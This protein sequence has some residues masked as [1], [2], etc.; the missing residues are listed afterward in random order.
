M[1]TKSL[2]LI[3]ALGLFSLTFITCSDDDGGNGGEDPNSIC[4]VEACAGNENFKAVCV[5][6]Y[7]DCI[8]R[9]GDP[10]QCAAAA[11]ETCTL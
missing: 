8:E 2:I 6:E 9:G 3:L 10:D 4:N 1:K 11:T 7:N 5:D